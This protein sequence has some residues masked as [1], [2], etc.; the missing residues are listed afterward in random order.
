[1][2]DASPIEY[3]SRTFNTI[4]AD[5]NADANLV[6]K[7]DWW[8]RIWA[9]VGDVLSVYLNA[10]ANNLYLRT[11]F[12]RQ[13]V[14]DLA[15]LID[16][17]VSPRATSSGVVLVFLKSTVSFPVTIAKAD[18]AALTPGT[19][20]I[21]SKRFEARAGV[22]VSSQV[23]DNFTADFTTNQLTV[24]R[25]FLLGEKVRLTTTGT[26]PAGLALLTDYWVIR[27][28][29]TVIKLAAS[30]ADAYAGVVV[31]FTDNGTGTHTL[32]LLSIQVT[33]Y[34]QQ[35]VTQ[36]S[37]GTASPTETWQELDMGDKFILRDTLEVEINS[38]AWPVLG[39]GAL[40]NTFVFSDPTDKHVKLVFNTDESA[41]LR[42]GNGTFGELPPAF[43]VLVTYAIGGGADSNVSANRVIIYAGSNTDVA[44]VSNPSA[45]TGGSNQESLDSAKRLA[46]ILLKTRDRFITTADG[47]ALALDFNGLSLARVNK[48]VFGVLSA[49]VVGVA[50][51]GGNP[52]SALK[53]S[54][55]TFLIDRTV[56]ESIDV[57][58]QDAT[59]TSVAVTSAAKMQSG[60]AFANVLPFFTLA[61]QLILTETGQEILDD[62]NAN[63]VSSATTLINTIF[64]ASFDSTNFGQISRLLTNFDPRD[65]GIDVQQ[66]DAFGFI[67]AFVNGIDYITIAAPSFPI[68]LAVDEITTPGTL[69][70]T[71]IP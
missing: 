69:T 8:K 40:S 23:T 42:F 49:Q 58:V 68:V 46:P 32:N 10:T 34:Q 67:D 59:I 51:G 33:M 27:V 66:S 21:S 71:E 36:N 20:I 35:S 9:G 56:L 28:S 39:T 18:L 55:Q 53:T 63:G 62:F 61:W 4:L 12:T 19:L 60:F 3:T 54:L 47:E 41:R 24:T 16:Y 38:V 65:F 30:L 26:L 45:M 43:D 48:N 31:P 64:S 17:E 22:T 7:P 25:D 14:T 2:S 5:I 15:E 57:R 13:A 50:S 6:D 52:S 11:A 70:L 29:A 44:A 1:M 37:V